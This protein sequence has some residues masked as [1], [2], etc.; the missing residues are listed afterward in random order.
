M[1]NL[2][3]HYLLLYLV[4]T[5]AGNIGANVFI[6]PQDIIAG[7]E[8]LNLAFTAQL[9]NTCPGLDPLEDGEEKQ[10]AGLMDDDAGDSREERAFRM[11]INTLGLNDLYINN[12][13]EDCHDGLTL[14][15]VID[16]IEPGT[17]HWNK[18]EMKPNNKFKKL[19]NCNYA[20]VLGKQLK[21]SVVNLGGADIVDRN[22][23]L[24]LGF[25][26]QLMRHHM[27]KFLASMS[28]KGKQVND[29]DILDWCNQT[30]AATGKKEQ[31]VGFSDQEI[32]KG[33]YFIYLIAGIR[34]DIVDWTLVT[35]GNTDDEKLLNAKYAISLAR[36]I[37][38]V[39]FLLPEDI[40]EVRPKMCLTFG[41]GA[42]AI[43]LARKK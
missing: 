11:W 34:E 37:G 12:L 21:M 10:L 42:M 32:A 17:V 36:K 9:F 24:I 19:S 4:V 2:I 29:K 18:V 7:N 20:V 15:K 25:A 31:I 26:W 5:N 41:A 43:G 22:K 39:I 14:L 35:D 40:V 38:A 23:K 30:V 1:L 8:K 27:L 3:F 33:K 16:K 13:F 28:V 6:K